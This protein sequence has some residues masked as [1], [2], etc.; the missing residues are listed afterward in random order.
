MTASGRSSLVSAAARITPARTS[1]NTGLG[2]PR[3]PFTVMFVLFPV[4]WA[5]GLAEAA[6][7]PCA[8]IMVV[9]LVKRGGALVPRGFALW[10]LFLLLMLVSVIGIDTSGR[11]IG[12]IYRALLY[13][14][15][16][17]VFVYLYN[18]RT[19]ISTRYV[20]GVLTI[21]WLVVI[22]GGY[23]GILMPE[24]SFRTPLGYVLPGS[25]QANDLVQEMVVRRATQYNPDS[26]FGFEPRPAAPFLYT[27][28]WG[29]V[30]SLLMPAVVAYAGYLRGTRR[31][32]LIVLAIPVSLV[33]AVLTLNRG[34]FLGLGVAVLYA[35]FR[36]AL[37]G[38]L[39]ALFGLG[40]IG[41]VGIAAALSLGLAD[42]LSERLTFS[43]STEDRANLYVEAITRTLSSPLFGFGAPRPSQTPGAP[44]VGTQGHV[45]TVLFSHGFPALIV[46]L[47]T[48]VYFF[49]A[50]A[51]VATTT[52]LAL[53]TMQLV[54]IVEVFYYGVL[55]NGLM[56]SFIAAA[57]ALRGDPV[58]EHVPLPLRRATGI[59]T[60]R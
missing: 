44:S 43:S 28:G 42:R 7:I 33:P 11:L 12:F 37:L 14:T 49:F 19:T 22:A 17:I 35:A 54:I 10:L 29:N 15:V 55:P 18:A 8:A 52:S 57:L 32:W 9:Y 21:F 20:L 41:I 31:F 51:R 45:W 38:R 6:W 27:N 2:L 26:V 1:G 53:H 59:S 36:L 3:W 30:Y 40:V 56:L 25:L 23:L 4:W 48:L 16:T 50:T 24:F 58:S 46:F 39:R 13:L 34:M 60:R 47:L 5:L